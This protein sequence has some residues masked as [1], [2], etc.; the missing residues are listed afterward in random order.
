[1][2]TE[3]Q[4]FEIKIDPLYTAEE[5]QAIAQDVV[6]YIRERTAD[7]RGIGGKKKFAGYSESYANSLEFKIAGKS[8]NDVNLT[9]S[10]DMLGAMDLLQE[11]IGKLV[12]GFENGSQENA[13]ADGNIRGTYGKDHQVGPKRDF[14]GLTKAELSDILK[15]YP[16]DAPQRRAEIRYTEKSTDIIMQAIKTKLHGEDTVAIPTFHGEE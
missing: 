12:I 5:R 14:L 13:I 6:D 9:Q 4:R 15:N 10:G 7:G 1:M 2:S 16:L 3:W 8:K 11:S